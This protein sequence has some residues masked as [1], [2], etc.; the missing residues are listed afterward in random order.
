MQRARTRLE[1]CELKCTHQD[2]AA[3]KQRPLDD[4]DVEHTRCRGCGTKKEIPLIPSASLMADPAI[5]AR[6]DTGDF[7]LQVR[8]LLKSRPR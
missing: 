1:D 3:T 8:S 6:L 2:A 5:V 7:S 4:E